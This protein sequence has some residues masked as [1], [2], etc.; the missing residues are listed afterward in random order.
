MISLNE[1]T[2]HIRG[3]LEEVDPWLKKAER[4]DG[5]QEIH[6]AGV[7]VRRLLREAVGVARGL[8]APQAE[9]QANAE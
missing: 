9:A 7:E 6:D 2:R 4:G 8:R 1:R 3:V 5:Q